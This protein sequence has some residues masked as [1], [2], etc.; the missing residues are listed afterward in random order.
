M[1]VDLKELSLTILV[2]VACV[3]VFVL[4]LRWII[5]PRFAIHLPGL[6][7]VHSDSP[8]HSARSHNS[9]AEGTAEFLKLTNNVGLLL[10]FLGL[11]IFMQDFSKAI[12]T[13]HTFAFHSKLLQRF[14]KA[15]MP[16]SET[17]MRLEPL[18]KNGDLIADKCNVYFHDRSAGPNSAIAFDK[19]MLSDQGQRLF[20]R[21]LH[22][23]GIPALAG[24]DESIAVVVQLMTSATSVHCDTLGKLEPLYYR[25]KN[26]AYLKEQYFE[27][28]QS[29]EARLDFLRSMTAVAAGGW[30]LFALTL[31][32]GLAFRLFVR[33]RESPLRA[34]LLQRASW[35][36]V[37]AL[38]IL[39]S[40]GLWTIDRGFVRAYHGTELNFNMRVYGYFEVA[41]LLP[42][43]AQ[44]ALR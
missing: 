8:T 13:S 42:Y 20:D 23:K 6:F 3:G 18:V 32:V 2:G 11:G 19:D 24:I 10:V 40:F 34:G 5:L 39:W 37:V 28:L 31:L 38:V 4:T 41:E 16:T 7:V 17:A 12:V 35:L 26:M 15:T 1:D 29:I 44:Q 43:P 36:H 14:A 27:E 25:A 33:R 30:L 22:S 21:I 9:T